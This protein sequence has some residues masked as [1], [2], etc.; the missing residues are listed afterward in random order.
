MDPA[1]RA[2]SD[3]LTKC[4]QAYASLD[5]LSCRQTGHLHSQ[6]LGGI[7]MANELVFYFRRPDQVRVEARE[8]SRTIL[9]ARGNRVVITAAPDRVFPE[10]YRHVGTSLDPDLQFS[11]V[12][13]EIVPMLLGLPG[14]WPD[15]LESRR[16]RVVGREKIDGHE[17]YRITGL[18]GDTRTVTY[19]VDTRAFLLRR[20][21]LRTVLSGRLPK[22]IE[23]GYGK[24]WQAQGKQGR[25][26][27]AQTE[28]EWKKLEGQVAIQDDTFRDFRLSK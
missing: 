8:P 5:S 20:R 7:D 18:M 19:W 22:E 25:E 15:S 2:A 6:A 16:P 11:G 27:W 26:L 13:A 1:S 28:E 3:I 17:C 12:A 9:V 14:A 24:G 10:G 21:E 23:E 4:R